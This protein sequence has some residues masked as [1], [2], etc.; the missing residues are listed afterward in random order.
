[1]PAAFFERVLG[2]HWKYSC[3]LWSETTRDL[4][5]AEAAMLEAT[6]TRAGLEDG[7]RVLDLGCGWGSL[8]LWIAEHFPRAQI[9]AVSNSHAQRAVI[10]TRAQERGFENLRV[11]T[12]DANEFRPQALLP[13]DRVVSIEMVEHMRNWEALLTRIASWL[14]PEGRVFLHYFSHRDY[15]YPYEDRGRGDWMARH[16]FGGGMM[17]SASLAE[18]LSGPF[19]VEESWQVSGLHYR[20]TAEAWLRNLDRHR[21]A[22]ESLFAQDL[23]ARAA[24]VQLQRWRMFF[25]GC[26]E[27]FGYRGGREWGVTHIRMRR[28]RS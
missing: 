24:R 23:G 18:R 11:V 17:P 26:A 1:M 12:A 20:H 6:C 15:S 2:P 28:D 4:G 3:A 8:S 5:A 9:L 25:L 13:L 10:E 27:L 7:M 19:A 21:D 22:L 14:A 16:F